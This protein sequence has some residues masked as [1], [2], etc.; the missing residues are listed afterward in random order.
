MKFHSTAIR[1]FRNKQEHVRAFEYQDYSISPHDHDFYEMNIISSGSGTHTIENASFRVKPGDVFIIP[2]GVMHSYVETEHLNVYHILLRKSFIEKNRKE[3]EHIPGFLQ[4]I[5]I[6][7]FLRQN[8]SDAMFLHLSGSQMIELQSDLKIITDQSR[9]NQE[10][11]FPLKEHIAWKILYWFSFLL[12]E[13]L[14]HKPHTASAQT[15]AI[16]RT[17]EYIHQNYG[18]KITIDELCKISFLSRS[19][20]LRN[21]QSICGCTPLQYLT[22][23]RKKQ[24]IERLEQNELSKTEIAHACGF[25]DLSHMMRILKKS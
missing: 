18:E 9:L 7:P 4:L 16:F 24:A 21:F 20:F 2:P 11:L 3:A 8:Y 10:S 23:Y 12:S 1:N 13:Q 19:T 22:G 14:Y 5:E 15:Q 25:Y 6:E 17:L